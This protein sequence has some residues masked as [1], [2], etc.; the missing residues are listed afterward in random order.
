VAKFG[1]S[2][3][4]R[5]DPGDSAVVRRH[6]DAVAGVAFVVRPA[7]LAPAPAAV[8]QVP[9][10]KRETLQSSDRLKITVYREKDLTG[11]YQVNDKGMISFPLIGQVKAAGFTPAQLQQNL[12]TTL[13][14]GYLVKPDINVER[15][16]DCNSK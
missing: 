12:V 16:P 8:G 2:P 4:R 11:E 15:V 3:C 7:V 14:N 9:A 6:P 13:S 10:P 1:Y 5:L